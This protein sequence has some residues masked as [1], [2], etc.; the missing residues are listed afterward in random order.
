[1]NPSAQPVP[2]V[3]DTFKGLNNVADPM[4]GGWEW[5]EVADN[6]DGTDSNGLALRD[7][8]TSFLAG[9]AINGAYATIDLS[10]LYIIDSGNLYRVMPDSTTLTLTTGLTGTPYWSEINTT[11]YLSCGQDK[12]QI[13]QDNTVL[14]WGVPKPAE[15]DVAA[16]TGTLFA[17]IVQVCTTFT[18]ATGR[19][20]GASIPVE[21]A[22][23]AGGG[24]SVSNIPQRAGYTAHLYATEPDGTVFYRVAS[25]PTQTAYNVVS[26][27]IGMELTTA[28]M[29]PPE[30]AGT[31]IGFFGGR[32][33]MADY[34]AS[35]DQTVIWFSQPLGYHLFKLDSDYFVVP[36]QVSQMAGSAELLLVTTLDAVFMYDGEKLV[37]V[38]DYGAVMGQ[39]VS[40]SADGKLYF[41]TVRG[42]CRAMPFENLTETRV[43][44]AP[45]VQ[46]GGAIVDSNG[47]R[48]YIAMVRQGGS[49]YNA[50]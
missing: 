21:I 15:S 39:H 25:L 17:G 26:T 1:M 40:T 22:V 50:R 32:A 3:L 31:N 43:S 27:P 12:L 10:R 47:F 29:Y 37:Q 18:D 7:G 11:V 9:T 23:S 20:G 38:A 24:I 36:G 14:T 48:K 41:W 42:L 45:G 19:E 6:V 13:E 28:S 44:V 35:V 2:T 33:F 5:Q 34:M 46:A 4:R 8:Y 30:P 16:I 49:A